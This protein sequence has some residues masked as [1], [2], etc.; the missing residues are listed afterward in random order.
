ML[1]VFLVVHFTHLARCSPLS[2]FGQALLSMDTWRF[3]RFLGA[4]GFSYR[5]LQCLVRG[6]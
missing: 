1:F 3:T 4:M 2:I 6:R 5:I